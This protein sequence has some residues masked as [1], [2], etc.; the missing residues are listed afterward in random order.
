MP[1][2]GS[3]GEHGRAAS[4][5]EKGLVLGVRKF[6]LEL[7]RGWAGGKKLEARELGG[8]RVHWKRTSPDLGMWVWDRENEN[9]DRVRD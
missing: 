8:E 2:P 1:Y 5:G 4:K 3:D 7:R 9:E 6:S